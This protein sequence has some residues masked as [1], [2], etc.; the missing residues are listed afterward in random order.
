MYALDG[1]NPGG[2]SNFPFI[3]N[4]LTKKTPNTRIKLVLGTAQTFL[5]TPHIDTF[6]FS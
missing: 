4:K 6:L 2:A 3:I 5:L 1:S